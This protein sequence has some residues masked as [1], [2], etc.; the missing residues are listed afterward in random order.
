MKIV[1]F[2]NSDAGL[3]LFRKELLE[4]LIDAGH[5]VVVSVPKGEY[6]NELTRLGCRLIETDFDRRGKNPFRELSLIRRYRRILKD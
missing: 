4:E 3:C 5:T 2:T 1:I 6:F